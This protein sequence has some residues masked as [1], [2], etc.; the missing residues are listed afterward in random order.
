MESWK[1]EIS[2]KVRIT[3]K[4]LIYVIGLPLSF[5]QLRSELSSESF[6]GSFGKVEKVFL[7]QIT[8]LNAE[9]I[10]QQL[11]GAHV[12][13][14]DNVS[15]STAIMAIDKMRIND[16]IVQADFGL[17]KYCQNFLR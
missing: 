7:N 16:Y 9:M 11:C 13:Y 12:T 2:Q 4:N 5:L 15:A 17:N 8:Y 10:P 6:F 14:A 1:E 3:Q